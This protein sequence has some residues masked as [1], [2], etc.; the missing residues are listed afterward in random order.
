MSS[1]PQVAISLMRRA[2][3]VV[4]ADVERNGQARLCGLRFADGKAEH[5]DNIPKPAGF[6]LARLTPG[7]TVT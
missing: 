3:V 4:V 7:G 6:V 1:G 2:R 5:P